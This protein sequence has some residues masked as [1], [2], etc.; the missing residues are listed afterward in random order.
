MLM[1]ENNHFYMKSGEQF[2][3]RIASGGAVAIQW[4]SAF[5]KLKNANRDSYSL[6]IVESIHRF[7][8]QNRIFTIVGLTLLFLIFLVLILAASADKNA[9]VNNL[10][11][12]SQADNHNISG[13][14]G[15]NDIVFTP[16]DKY[17][18]IK[19]NLEIIALSIVQSENWNKQ[20]IVD[21]AYSWN[22]LNQRQQGELKKTVWFQLLENDLVN[23]VGGQHTASGYSNDRAKLLTILSDKLNIQMPTAI[24]AVAL[25]DSSADAAGGSSSDK[26]VTMAQNSMSESE[27]GDQSETKIKTSNVVHNEEVAR[28]ENELF[29]QKAA[30]EGLLSQ[31][32]LEPQLNLSAVAKPQDTEIAAAEVA[33]ETKTT[34]ASAGQAELLPLPQQSTNPSPVVADQPRPTIH[35]VIRTPPPPGA[36]ELSASVAP[37]SVPTASAGKNNPS[38][39]NN[40]ESND[41]A[42][43]DAELTKL[44]SQLVNSYEKGNIDTFAS[45]FASNAVSNDEANLKTIRQ[46][47]ENLFATTSDRRMIIGDIKWDFSSN[48]ATGNAS[49]E[50]AVKPS[51]AAKAQ[52][53]TGKVQIVVEK[54]P[55]GVQITKLFHQLK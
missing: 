18:K 2:K 21:F 39:S 35:K 20:H 22:E 42:F 46:D 47:Y 29:K 54:K 3:S 38:S 36:Q 8:R 19:Y 50:V 27:A 23:I 48:T 16:Q 30:A 31:K 34:L 28:L 52:K 11:S 32:K 51:G 26:D 13:S 10:R 5:D 1:V 17:T 53:Y 4:F 6:G 40:G 45:L 12:V 25:S 41:A 37:I 49:M 33:Q 7:Y 14:T 9:P 15:N 43:S 55:D 24:R 44:T